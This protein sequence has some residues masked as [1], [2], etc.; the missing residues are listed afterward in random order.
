MMMQ[1]TRG[2]RPTPGFPVQTVQASPANSPKPL[3]KPPQPALQGFF[4]DSLSAA[5]A[6]QLLSCGL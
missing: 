1:D 5:F 6:A 2:L 3:K 4:R